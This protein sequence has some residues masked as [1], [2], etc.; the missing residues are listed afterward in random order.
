[1]SAEAARAEEAELRTLYARLHAI[2]RARR[3]GD[4]TAAPA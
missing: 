4:E 2:A 3:G 1:V